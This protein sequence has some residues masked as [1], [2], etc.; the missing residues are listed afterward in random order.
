V[1]N[2]PLIMSHAG[3]CP[4][5]A[6]GHTDAAKRI[7]DATM[8]QWVAG[9]WDM[10]VGK[11]MAF[12]LEDG[13]SDN[14]LYDNYRDAVRHQGN[15]EMLYMYVKLHPGGMSVCEAEAMLKF[16]RQAHSN[17]FR[18]PDP[19]HRAGGHVLIPR[20]GMDKIKAQIRAL[21]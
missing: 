2:V 21:K 4:A 1:S 6:L 10:T 5:R 11:F 7:S 14:V 8:L 9:G 3:G 18:M 13:R 20:I 15:N 17:G 12:K 19:D 16:N